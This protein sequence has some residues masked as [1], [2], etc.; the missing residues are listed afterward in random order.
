[1]NYGSSYYRQPGRPNG[2]WTNSTLIDELRPNLTTVELSGGIN[3]SS[4]SI[5][6]LTGYKQD[7]KWHNKK[8]DIKLNAEEWL[9]TGESVYCVCAHH[10]EMHCTIRDKYGLVINIH[11]HGEN[12]LCTCEHFMTRK[13]RVLNDEGINKLTSILSEDRK[14]DTLFWPKIAGTII[15]LEKMSDDFERSSNSKTSDHLVF[16]E[17]Y[18]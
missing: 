1:V 17:V 7:C 8:H 11:C 14:C 2:S 10:V 9:W 18:G 3:H 13:F 15:L 12:E 4:S 6:E 5:N 16:G